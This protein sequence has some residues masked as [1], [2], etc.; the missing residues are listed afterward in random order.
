MAENP[1]REMKEIG[2]V[3]LSDIVSAVGAGVEQGDGFA[4]RNYVRSVF[5]MI[6]ADVFQMKRAIIYVWKRWPFDLDADDLELLVEE[7]L[8]VSSGKKKPFP[9]FSDNLKF[10][11][12]TFCKAHRFQLQADYQSVQWLSLLNALKIRDRITHPKQLKEIDVTNDDLKIIRMAAE[13]YFT[14]RARLFSSAIDWLKEQT[15]S[16]YCIL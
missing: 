1:M 3:L 10:V 12:S 5:A 8:S 13:W 2:D 9:K 4:R 11:I 16:G 6:D 7:K 15:A 14:H